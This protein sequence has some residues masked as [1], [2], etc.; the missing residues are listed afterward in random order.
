[1]QNGLGLCAHRAV[2]YDHVFWLKV[3]SEPAGRDLFAAVNFGA[4][5][6][7]YRLAAISVCIFFVKDLSSPTY[8]IQNLF[9]QVGSFF[10]KLP[11][12]ALLG[13]SAC[14]RQL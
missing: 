2:V 4:L 13:G 6:Q 1:M 7:P 11:C 3:D 10:K 5:G 8:K 9:K 12:L 14:S